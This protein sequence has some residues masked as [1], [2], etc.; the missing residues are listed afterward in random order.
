MSGNSWFSLLII[1]LVFWVV[2]FV[3]FWYNPKQAREEVIEEDWNGIPYEHLK[4]NKT[5]EVVIVTAICVGCS[6]LIW[7]LANAGV[8]V[9]K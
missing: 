5:M 7:A 2:P 8:L 6:W 9:W 3:L 4:F 1:V